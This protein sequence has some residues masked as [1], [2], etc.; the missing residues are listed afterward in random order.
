MSEQQSQLIYFISTLLLSLGW[1]GGCTEGRS[2]FPSLPGEMFTIKTCWSSPA[3]SPHITSSLLQG[4]FNVSGE[5][6]GLTAISLDSHRGERERERAGKLP[7]C[8]TEGLAQSRGGFRL[9]GDLWSDW[10]PTVS[11]TAAPWRALPAILLARNGIK[12]HDQCLVS[13][14]HHKKRKQRQQPNPRWQKPHS[15]L[16]MA[17]GVAHSCFPVHSGCLLH[18]WIPTSASFLQGSKLQLW[19]F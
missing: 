5:K 15:K 14:W 18:V 13:R 7:C 10:F 9:L 11:Q 4:I 8:D 1:L 12:Q 16:L 2:C 17:S 19:A 6:E 3:P